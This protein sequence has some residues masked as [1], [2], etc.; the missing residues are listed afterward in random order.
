MA[1]IFILLALCEGN[2]P[3]TSG[4]S[5]QRDSDAELCDVLFVVSFNKLLNK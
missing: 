4:Y 2:P 1:M 5:S 3:I